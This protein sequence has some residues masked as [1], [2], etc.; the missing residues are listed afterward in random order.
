MQ[1]EGIEDPRD[2]AL[3]YMCRL[4]DPIQYRR[5]SP[6]RGLDPSHFE[7][8][9][10]FYDNSA[11]VTQFLL[12]TGAFSVR[13]DLATPGYHA[14]LAEDLAPYGRSLLQV[15]DESQVA[16]NDTGG[17][18]LIGRMVAAGRRLGVRLGTSRRVVGL[19]QA[20]SGRIV[21]VET[22]G[23]RSTE[24]IGSR[25]GVVFCTGG[26]LHNRSL[27]KTFLRGPV[28][29]G[30]AFEGNTGDFL[31]MASELGVRL[32]NMSHAW[33]DQV[34]LERTLSTPSTIEDVWMPFG[35]S[36]VIVNRLGQRVVNE[37]M[38]YNERAQAHF[39]WDAALREYPNRLLFMIYDDVVAS[40][41][42][43]S[44]FR[45]P[46]PPPGESAG[47]V[48]SASSLGELTTAVA[49]RLK[50]LGASAMGVELHEDFEARLRRTVETFSDH[51]RRGT[52]PDF[53][54]G[55]TPIQL[56]WGSSSRTDFPN[57]TLA[58]F[59]AT[60]PFHCIILAAGALDTKGGPM[61]DVKCRVLDYDGE[62]IAG[63]YGAGNCVASAAGQAYW[64]AGG[65][66]G[67][68]LVFGHLAG[69]QV[70]LEL[71]ASNR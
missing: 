34:V 71:A 54:R 32:G 14:D 22:H 38:V 48:I 55:E 59:S 60:G 46:V 70:A 26:F 69:E 28:A 2:A 35:D 9:A 57:P 42:S 19:L 6:N 12:D 47:Y 44:P 31:E 65:T 43:T 8:I 62:P 21:G 25:G 36:M 51:A 11:R 4:A 23:R 3:D 41:P 53:D 30:C 13:L 27:A 64:S 17:S 29:G 67:P 40:D 50:T 18:V 45:Q 49:A 52:D 7:R 37:K 1:R 39:V 15:R 20:E 16:A 61:V 66:I 24:L 56:A 68:A 5:G 10:S 63:L 33:W 58:P